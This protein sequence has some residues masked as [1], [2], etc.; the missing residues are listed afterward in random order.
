[1]VCSKVFLIVICFFFVTS[2]AIASLNTLDFKVLDKSNNTDLSQMIFAYDIA[3]D[4]ANN[5]HIIWSRPTGSGSDQVVYKRR[6]NGVWSND[7]ILTSN[8]LRDYLSINIKIANDGNVYACYLVTRNGINY[9]VGRPISSN[10]VIRPEITV[11][12]G[13]W[14]TIMQ[15]DSNN[16]PIYIRDNINNGASSLALLKTS[17]GQTWS[18]SFLNLPSVTEFRLAD[19]V[20]N[21]GF[22]YLTYGDTCCTRKVLNGKGSSAYVNGSFHNLWYAVSSDGVTWNSGQ[23]DNGSP[24]YEMEFWTSLEVVNGVPWIGYYVY[25][26][27]NK[28]YNTGTYARIVTLNNNRWISTHT[29]ATFPDAREGAALSLNLDKDGYT[30]GIWDFSPD[31]THNADFLGADGNIAIATDVTQPVISATPHTPS[32][33]LL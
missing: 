23:V 6:I 16:L 10:G 18:K 13:S 8:A 19:F 14:H 29:D 27:Y 24:V 1:M 31:N 33:S 11:D 25:N 15:I 17:N 21:N 22:F 3:V 7:I 28:N 32:G 26:E 2:N 5:V 9:L 20:Y 12:I 4:S 30:L